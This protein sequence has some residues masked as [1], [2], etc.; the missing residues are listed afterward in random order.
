MGARAFPKASPGTTSANGV[1]GG[2][3]E[4]AVTLYDGAAGARG[5]VLSEAVWQRVYIYMD[6]Y[7]DRCS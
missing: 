3:A 2:A 5:Q 7:S 4:G 1:G 6:T